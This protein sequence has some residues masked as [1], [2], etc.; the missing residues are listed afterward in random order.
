MNIPSLNVYRQKLQGSLIY[1]HKKFEYWDKH[2]QNLYEG[3]TFKE[4]KNVSKFSII[5]ES[6]FK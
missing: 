4:M 3:G 2:L 6:Y 5:V 1:F